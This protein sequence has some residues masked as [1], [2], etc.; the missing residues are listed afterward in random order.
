MIPKNIQPSVPFISDEN[1]RVT[2]AADFYCKVT[3][4]KERQAKLVLKVVIHDDHDQVKGEQYR[5]A[6]DARELREGRKR[7]NE[8]S[9]N[10]SKYSSGC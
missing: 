4:V 2:L 7:L 3:R 10:L 9:H 8:L 5:S 6:I 1:K